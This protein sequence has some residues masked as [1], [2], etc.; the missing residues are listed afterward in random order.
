MT[1][2][3]LSLKA[4]TVMLKAFQSTQDV[5]K[6]DMT[7]YGLN[8]TEF[9][10][11]E[12]LYSK[13]EQQIQH[14]GKRILLSSSSMTYVI[15]KL[16]QKGHIERKPCATDRRVIFAHITEKG[17]N[18]MEEAFPLHEK[19]I[20]ELFSVL[21]EEELETVIPLVKKVGIAAAG[22]STKNK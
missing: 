20:T 19:M 16:E 1:R 10:V 2:E 8:P 12:L 18:F 21:T 6:Q 17:K 14:I 9:A 4:L 3:E 15:D 7:K 22:Q 13:G 11:L 5:I